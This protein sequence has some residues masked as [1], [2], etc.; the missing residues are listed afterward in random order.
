MER[1]RGLGG[2][3]FAQ[4]ALV[5]NLPTEVLL[6]TLREMGADLPELEPLDVLIQR[7]GEIG[8]RYGQAVQ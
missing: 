2:C 1:L 6:A 4:D 7:S 3:P 8:K 5:G